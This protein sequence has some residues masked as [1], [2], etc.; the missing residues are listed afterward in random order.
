MKDVMIVSTTSADSIE[1]TV[2]KKKQKHV[3]TKEKYIQVFNIDGEIDVRVF[4]TG[5]FFV[6]TKDAL[7]V[8]ILSNSH[9]RS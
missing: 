2:C 5:G 4:N 7:E 9:H 8:P 3:W 6:H 1:L